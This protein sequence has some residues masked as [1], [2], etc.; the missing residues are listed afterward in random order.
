MMISLGHLFSRIRILD[1][2]LSLVLA[3]TK[4]KVIPDVYVFFHDY[5][6]H[7]QYGG[8]GIMCVLVEYLGSFNIYKMFTAIYYGLILKY[9]NGYLPKHTLDESHPST[10]LYFHQELG[11][12]FSKI[13]QGIDVKVRLWHDDMLCHLVWHMFSFSERF[14][15]LNKV[16]KNV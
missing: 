1:G 9:I 14:L 15:T 8:F 2:C 13:V 11:W 16:W 10:P 4:I 3:K 7:H 6:T 12:I 5:S